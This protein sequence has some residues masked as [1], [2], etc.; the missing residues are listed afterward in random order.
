MVR[1]YRIRILGVPYGDEAVPAWRWGI[2]LG[3]RYDDEGR[4]EC[5]ILGISSRTRTNDCIGGHGQCWS[6]DRVLMKAFIWKAKEDT[7]QVNR[8]H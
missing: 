2:G 5:E 1:S 6:Y 3:F 8:V 4:K 7:S